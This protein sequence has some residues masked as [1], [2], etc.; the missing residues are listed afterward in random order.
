MTENYI[1]DQYFEGIENDCLF[2]QTQRSNYENCT[3]A[4]CNFKQTDMSEVRFYDCR[5][6]NCDLSLTDVKGTVFQNIAFH[7]CKLSGVLFDKCNQFGLEL[8]FYDTKLDHSSFYDLKINRAVFVQCSLKGVDYSAAQLKEAQFNGSDLTDAKFDQSHLE[9]AD[10][11]AAV[12]FVINPE[13]NKVKGAVFSMD[14]LPGL[15]EAY[16]I[17]IAP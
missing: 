14:G 11:R 12:H 10:F 3:F 2:W 5:F 1:Q 16:K 17:K 13:L 9:K 7:G 6:E 4:A 8:K 15:L